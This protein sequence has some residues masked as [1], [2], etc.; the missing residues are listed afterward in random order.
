MP[1]F[2]QKPKSSAC[3][4]PECPG[5]SSPSCMASGGE[6]KG[7]NKSYDPEGSPNSGTS[8]AGIHVRAGGETGKRLA[9]YEHKKTLGELKMMPKPKLYAEGGSVES[10]SKRADNEKGVHAGESEPGASKKSQGMSMAGVF[11]RNSEDPR[12]K[13]M[14]VDEHHKVLGEMK[15]MK[16][17]NLYAEGGE[18]HEDEAQDKELIDEELHNHMGEELMAAFDAK[19]KKR[20]MEAI[21]AIVMSA[22]SKE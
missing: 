9:K 1:A 4:G 12:S 18:V 3:P 11:S 6:I 2:M 20:I 17:P 7:V 21:D 22:L 14:A 13:K 19:D 15:T 10:Y 16:K 5:C 8:E